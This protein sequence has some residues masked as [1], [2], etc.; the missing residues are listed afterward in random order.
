MEG[1]EGIKV[2]FMVGAREVGPRVGKVDVGDVV[3]LY[4]GGLVGAFVGAGGLRIVKTT[5]GLKSKAVPLLLYCALNT[6]TTSIKG[7]FL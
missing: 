1:P 6:I 2:D 5:L 4:V 7:G 3:G